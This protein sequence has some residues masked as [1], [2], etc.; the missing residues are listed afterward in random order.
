M[1]YLRE[2][3]IIINLIFALLLV[4]IF[5]Y[6]GTFSST[7]AYPISAI[8]RQTVTSTGLQRALSELM[9][10]NLNTALQLNI[11]SLGIFIFFITELLIRLIFS[12]IYIKTD[13][14]KKIIIADAIISIILFL[15]AFMPM[16]IKQ[17]MLN[18]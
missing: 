11:Y 12:I 5:C 9:R 16:A 15:S 18:I 6:F 7:D 2:P 1:Q 13:K 8:T 14:K 3:Y 17:I 4:A 10:G